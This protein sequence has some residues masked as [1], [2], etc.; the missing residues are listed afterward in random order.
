YRIIVTRDLNKD[1]PEYVSAIYV[2]GLLYQDAGDYKQALQAFGTCDENPLKNRA[3]Y[4]G[5]LLGPQ[6]KD[7]IREVLRLQ[8]IDDDMQNRILDIHHRG[9]LR[10]NSKAP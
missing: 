1:S 5:L 8:K 10:C 2:V 9:L 7:S 4:R 3:Y 6:L